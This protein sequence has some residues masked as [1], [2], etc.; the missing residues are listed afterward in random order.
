MP[1]IRLG[2]AGVDT[3]AIPNGKA[4]VNLRCKLDVSH[5]RR[6][7]P[8]PE[9]EPEPVPDPDLFYSCDEATLRS[10]SW[11]LSYIMQSMH[12]AGI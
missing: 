8:V 6:P 2:I 10:P 11:S 5:R 12:D 7:V 4:T 1:Y 3:T 9:P